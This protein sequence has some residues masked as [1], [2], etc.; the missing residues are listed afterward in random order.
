[1]A[2]A[3]G[4]L[5]ALTG[6]LVQYHVPF[7]VLEIPHALDPVLHIQIIVN[8][9]E[10]TTKYNKIDVLVLAWY[11]LLMSGV[12]GREDDS[13]V[14]GGEAV[15]LAELYEEV[16]GVHRAASVAFTGAGFDGGVRLSP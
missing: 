7:L 12:G 11:P 15:V 5:D 16:R 9:R 4:G 6:D 1:V 2:L 13:G 14:A 3:T 8:F 10:N